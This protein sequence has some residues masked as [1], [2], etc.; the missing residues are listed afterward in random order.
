MIPGRLVQGSFSLICLSAVFDLFPF[1]PCNQQVFEDTCHKIFVS[2]DDH[3]IDRRAF[4]PQHR[5]PESP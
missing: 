5:H 1:C 4:A 2:T 3:T